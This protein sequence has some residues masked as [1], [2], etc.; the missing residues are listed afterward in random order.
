M[1]GFWKRQL[2]QQVKTAVA[3]MSLREDFEAVCQKADDAWASLQPNKEIAAASGAS[4]S[5]GAG[6]SAASDAEVAA[7][8]GRGRGRNQRRAGQRGRGGQGR[9]Q[10]RGA[11]QQQQGARQRHPTDNPPEECCDQHYQYGKSAWYC[12]SRGTC[13]WRDDTTGRNSN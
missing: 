11:H 8:R 3:G 7:V 4:A 9:G 6:A 10:G 12:T 13:P 5:A 2:P 1:T